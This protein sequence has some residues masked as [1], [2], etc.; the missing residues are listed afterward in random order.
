MNHLQFAFT[1]RNSFWRYLIVFIVVLFAANSVGAAPMLFFYI[2]AL[3]NDPSAAIK[4]TENPSD[5]TVLGVSQ[6]TSLFLMLFPF[7]AVTTAFALIVKPLHDRTLMQ[8]INGS[9]SFRWGRLLSGAGVWA[10]LSAIYLFAYLKAEPDNFSLNNTSITLLPLILISITL[11][12]FQAGSE[13]LLMRGYLMQGFYRAVPKKWVPLLLTSVI[14][15][16]LHSFNPEVKDFGFLT[17]MPQYILFGLVFGI[18]VL[19]DDGIEIAIGAHSANNIFL[20]VMLTHKSS[21]LQTPSVFEQLDVFPW[22]EFA[23]LFVMSSVFLVLLGKKY[24]W[25]VRSLR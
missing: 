2:K 11:I 19:L 24:G 9:G 4:L 25:S 6:N 12:P 7:L 18:T 14:F 1:G 17:M 5:F 16:L 22:L 20:A 8:T 15:G 23:G 21:A 13:E 3:I 10:A